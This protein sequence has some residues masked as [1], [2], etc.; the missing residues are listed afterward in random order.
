MLCIGAGIKCAAL[1]AGDIS[2]TKVASVNKRAVACVHAARFVGVKEE[3]RAVGTVNN[4]LPKELLALAP[5][6]CLIAAGQNEMKFNF[7]VF[8]FRRKYAKRGKHIKAK[9]AA[10]AKFAKA[11]ANQIF[12][13]FIKSFY[14]RKPPA[15]GKGAV[16]RKATNFYSD[17]SFLFSFSIT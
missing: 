5:T 7:R 4:I 11:I 2:N 8:F 3:L 9:S 14:Q 6:L 17:S 16:T 13:G 10:C 1:A 15:C 12:N